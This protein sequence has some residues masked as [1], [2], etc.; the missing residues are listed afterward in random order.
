[1]P[2]SDHDIQASQN[3]LV[4]TGIC[5]NCGASAPEA[6][7]PQCGQE[8]VLHPPTLHEFLHE[9]FSHYVAIDGPLFRTIWLLLS[10][11]GRLTKE[12]LAGRKRQFILP[13]RLYLTISL[14]VW[15]GIGII[16]H[17][18]LDEHPIFTGPLDNVEIVNIGL[19]SPRVSITNGVFSCVGLPDFSCKKLKRQF[20]RSEEELRSELDN[21]PIHV[22][23]YMSYSMFATVFLF[24]AFA[25]LMF[26]NRHM[27]YGEHLVFAFHLHGVGLICMLLFGLF[28]GITTIAVLLWGCTYYLLAL[29]RVYEGS[30]LSILWRGSIAA[31][32]DLIGMLI[33]TLLAGFIT[34]IF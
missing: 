16:Q 28:P 21:I 12:Y 15:A 23:S 1:M 17:V 10:A 7:C 33:C 14:L 6:Y 18:R 32:L 34:V 9:F 19:A 8:T 11:P 30:W 20:G 26:R 25:N 2:Q 27:L 31:I 5:R 29:K 4:S 3:H 13:L 24:A 22:L